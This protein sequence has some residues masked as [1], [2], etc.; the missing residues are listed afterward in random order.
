MRINTDLKA[1]INVMV[2]SSGSGKSYRTKRA[3]EKEKRLLIW[4]I[5]D[6]HGNIKGIV[7]HTDL[8]ALAA[9]LLNAKTGKFRYVGKL[10]ADEFETFCNMVFAW[11]H[12]VC[13]VEEL[14]GVTSPSKAPSGWHT[15]VSRGR[16]RGIK[17]YAITQRPAESDK[18]V[19]GNA[20]CISCGW[21]R[22]HSD[23]VYMSKEMSLDIKHINGLNKDYFE[24][25]EAFDNGEFVRGSTEKSRAGAIRN[26][27][28]TEK[29][30]QEDVLQA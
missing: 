11:G 8:K 1:N 26:H 14:A 19:L 29:S 9:E 21:L 10:L 24:Y 6:E 2:G 4:D 27:E 17:I 16:K 18:T 20:S 15:L 13:V 7:T 12:C 3:I 28:P 23:K 25:I 5:D 30:Q 22:K